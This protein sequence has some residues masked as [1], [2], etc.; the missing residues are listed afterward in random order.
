MN[1]ELPALDRAKLLQVEASRGF[2]R[3]PVPAPQAP[4]TG[5]STLK[6]V[7]GL[8]RPT[9]AGVRAEAAVAPLGIRADISK[10]PAQPPDRYW[11]EGGGTGP[12]PP[13]SS[14]PA[15]PTQPVPRA[16]PGRSCR[17][18]SRRLHHSA[19]SPCCRM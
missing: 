4:D 9:E 10:W 3:D 2:T 19:R 6:G 1:L 8:C 17:P 12:R 18:P 16:S 14:W 15:R 7:A 5:E 11:R 13:R